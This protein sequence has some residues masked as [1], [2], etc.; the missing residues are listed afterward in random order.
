MKIG[1]LIKL[2]AGHALCDYPLQGDFLSKAKNHASPLSGVPYQH[3]LTAHAAIHSGMVLKVT[4]SVPLALAE[5][6]IHT[7]TDYAKCAGKINFNQDQAIHYGCKVLWALLA[8][9]GD[10][11]Q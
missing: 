9:R 6:A 3:A 2:L 1:T 8:P 10:V 5:F 4:N 7:A 11:R